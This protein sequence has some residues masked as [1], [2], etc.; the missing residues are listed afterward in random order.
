VRKL[1]F[2][3]P[4]R[5]VSIDYARK[6]VLVIGVDAGFS[7]DA[8]M[9]AGAA[10]GF[11]D[12]LPGLSF[13]KP[14]VVPGEPL[15]LEILSFLDAV[16]RRVQPRVTARQGRDALGL[17]LEIQRAMVEHAGRAG[18]GDFFLAG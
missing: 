7:L 12:G 16:R 18:L 15:R 10:A 5:Y 4:R 14:V 9:A 17:A 11:S 13:E 3:E 1:R 8:A 2:F 6:D